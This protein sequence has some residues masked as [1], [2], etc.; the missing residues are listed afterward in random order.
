MSAY[1]AGTLLSLAQDH[2]QVLLEVDPL[3]HWEFLEQLVELEQKVEQK[4]EQ[5]AEWMV[6]LPVQLE[7]V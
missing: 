3:D 5:K 4:V 1:L 6:E 2:I 7:Q